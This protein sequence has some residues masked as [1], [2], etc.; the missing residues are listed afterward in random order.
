MNLRER[1][2]GIALVGT[3]LIGL[4]STTVGANEIKFARY[5]H[6]SNDGKMTFS[7]H[8]DIWLADRD[9]GN[10]R[11]LTAHVARDVFPRFS[12]DGKHIAFTSDR[13]GNDDIWVMGIEGGEPEQVTKHSTTD[14]MLYWTPCGK[15]ILMSSSRSSSPWGSPLYIVPLDGA[16][17]TPLPMDIAAAGMIHPDGEKVAFNRIGFP[18]FFYWRKGYRGNRNTD[19]YVQDL[20]GDREIR[21]LTDLDIKAFRS[22]TQDTY[23]M[24]GADGMIYFMSERDG[25]FNIWRISP[26]GGEPE[27]ITDHDKDGVQYPSI[28]PDGTT[29]I[30]ENEFELWTL[31]IPDG[32]PER[33][34]IEMAFDPK[35]NLVSFIDVENTASGFSPSPDG[36][37]VCVDSHGEIMEVPVDPNE[38]EKRWITQSAWRDQR[39]KYSPD[40]KYVSYI[41]DE[42]GDDEIWLFELETGQRRQLTHQKSL[43][44]SYLWSPDSKSLLFTAD[45][46][47]YMVDVETGEIDE[48]AHNEEGGYSVYSFSD[49]G[50][51][52][53]Y[54]RSNPDL[55]YDVYLFNIE[56]REEHNVTQH[57]FSEWGGGFLTPDKKHVVFTSNR[58]GSG[59]V[60]AVSLLKVTEDPDDPLVKASKDKDKNKPDKPQKGKPG[61][62]E[63]EK[64]SEPED[65]TNEGEKPADESKT[66]P[67][68]ES[69]QP[70]DEDEEV[71]DKPSVIE[72]DLEG[73]ADRPWQLS[74]G[75]ES[76]S[77][78]FLSADGKNVIYRQDN[79]L[80]SVDLK[81]ENAKKLAD[82]PF[83]GLTLTADGKSLFYSSDGQ[84]YKMSSSGDKKK[85]IPFSFRV[86]VD[87]RAEW[88]QIFEEAWRVMKYIFYDPDMHGV[89]W[90]ATKEK[91]KPFLKYV[92][93]NQDLY[94][95]CN[96]MLGELHASHTYVS[97]P[98]TQSMDRLYST[99]SLGFE[100]AGDGSYYRV[101]YIYPKGP[102]DKEW[103]DIKVGDYV[104]AIDGH[105]VRAGDNYY[106]ILN[107]LVND[108]VNIKM[109]T[110]KPGADEGV[111]MMG[112]PR[113]ERVRSIDS[114]RNLAYEAWVE[115][116]RE[117]VDEWSGGK[118]GYV[119]IRYMTRDALARFERE[120]NQFWNKN[121][122]IIDIRYNGGGNIDQQL[123]DI[124]ERKPYEYIYYRL[125]GRAY[126]RRPRQAIAG[127]QVMLIN[128]FSG[129]D[130]EVTSQAFRD[131]GLGR[132]VGTPTYGGVIWTGRRGLLNGARIRAPGGLSVT[133][134]PSNEYNYGI[135]LERFGVAPDVW[136]ENSPQDELD[137]FDR[138]LKAAVEE[139]LRM[140]AEDDWQYGEDD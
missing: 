64:K 28:S 1:A 13:F 24:W 57:R 49:D 129:S 120:I 82:G 54:T 132:I 114:T 135:N 93:E 109:A 14:R 18:Y 50:E 72:M 112:D 30:Y 19:I 96:E 99:P 56:D 110:P 16:L 80:W 128:A 44:E 4:M 130:S 46:R 66:S 12:P 98:P 75:K 123:I 40:G 41:S 103:L 138:E 111:E 58:S 116:N 29:I 86:K 117:L 11:R 137:G 63:D 62:K 53:V 68:N 119:H 88:E 140:L 118:I 115:H 113:T 126:G 47:M 3:A 34:T 21:Q 94:D 136:V 26:D 78:F 73:I 38:G 81:G 48:L 45:N 76:V 139:A 52:L 31:D 79:V 121:G 131:L 17:P 84:V 100:M 108:Y 134:D 77:K 7:Y 20:I 5:P 71:E 42:S 2:L 65:K 60:Y 106:P 67:E 37:F 101:S 23:P 127:P 43:K 59:Q 105:E 83:D 8:G 69:A 15:G 9:G 97:G 32:E 122:M 27:Q 133:Y 25:I 90:E 61:D 39:P 124:L 85:S 89:D 36:E 125:M 51:W 70:I 92:G 10:P 74:K 55:N 33:V 95:L 6:I 87:H 35:R 22:H 107:E 102:A 91:Y 104:L